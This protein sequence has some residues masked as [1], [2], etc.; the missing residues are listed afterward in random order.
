MHDRR[1]STTKE[2][3][4][5]QEQP[6]ATR[7]HDGDGTSTTIFSFFI[8]FRPDMPDFNAPKT[9]LISNSPAAIDFFFFFF[10][11][12][13]FFHALFFLFGYQG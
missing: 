7:R 8:G 12:F 2:K 5:W 4:N 3:V 6:H 10:L 13:S 1:L 11:F 9:S